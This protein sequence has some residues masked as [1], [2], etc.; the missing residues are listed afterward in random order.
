MIRKLW[1]YNIFITTYS[2]DR[3]FSSIYKFWYEHLNYK[4]IIRTCIQN[5]GKGLVLQNPRNS[6][7][8]FQYTVDTLLW[9]GGHM[10]SNGETTVTKMITLHMQNILT[11]L[12]MF[13]NLT[14]WFVFYISIYIYYVYILVL[15]NALPWI[16]YKWRRLLNNCYT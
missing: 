8:I 12:S 16:K 1:I 13:H 15:P 7:V 2:A 6:V 14:Q 3:K 11:Y 5:R 4:F 9:V 10:E